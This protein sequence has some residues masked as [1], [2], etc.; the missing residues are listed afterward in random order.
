MVRTTCDNCG[1]NICKSPSRLEKNKHNFCD[2]AC[3]KEWLNDNK[4]L[5]SERNKKTA[6]KYWKRR[7]EKHNTIN[8]LEKTI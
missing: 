6:I 3:Y 1:N 4:D 5:V 7:N 8:V 2:K